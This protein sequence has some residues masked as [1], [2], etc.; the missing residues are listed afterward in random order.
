MPIPETLSMYG[1]TV[2]LAPTYS[3]DLATTRRSAKDSSDTRHTVDII[4]TLPKGG[5]HRHVIRY[6]FQPL[7]TVAIPNGSATVTLTMDH[8]ESLPDRGSGVATE[9]LTLM[10]QY[11]DEVA[12][13][14]Q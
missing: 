4:Q 7:P 2:V 10:T 1:G 8:P 3:G 5:R 6:T 11:L 13:G 14:Q 9:M 12:L